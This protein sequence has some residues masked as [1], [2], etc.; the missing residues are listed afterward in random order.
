MA[1]LIKV[2]KGLDIP[3]QGAANAALR[4]VCEPTECGI[5]P[6][7]F[8][9]FRWKVA[10]KEG[11]KVA[12]GSPLLFAK[13]NPDLLIT[14]PLAGT[15]TEIRRGERRHID[16]VVVV[17]SGA[18]A[19]DVIHD[20]TDV[21]GNRDALVKLIC[22]AGLWVF[23]R[24]RPYDIVPDPTV[25][26]RDIFVTCFD[27]A[28]LAPDVVTNE[29]AA[30]MERGLEALSSL[31]SGRVYLGIPEESSFTSRAA[32]VYEFQ[33]PHP[34]G[35]TGVQASLIKPVNKGEVI[36]TLDARTAVRIGRLLATG[37]LDTSANVAVTGPLAQNPCMIDTRIGASLASLLK[38]H[39]PSDTSDMRVISGNVLTGAKA[40]VAEGFLRFPYRQITL[41]EEGAHADEFMGWASLSMKK[42]SVKRSFLS[43][44]FGKETNLRFDSRLHGGRRAPILSGELDRVF[45][46]D[47]YP[48]YLLRAIEARDIDRMEQLGI[49][50]VAPEDFALPEFVDTS[51]E[52]LQAIVRDGLDY[53]RAEIS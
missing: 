43:R 1:N 25:V 32:V 34:A 17:G 2:K 13:E 20:T 3:L 48:E 12:E 53:L 18:K 44:L 37:R 14:S 42:Y 7:D 35:N 26:P 24:Q 29:M 21:A 45:P 46:M 38:G 50:E 8:P 40:D 23:M 9:G 28:P 52:P 31:T 6:D 22:T 39:L 47:I 27:T 15:V 16:A 33:G 41:I 4:D 11:D 36:W 5:V 30:D 19:D 49:Y 10:V 51:K